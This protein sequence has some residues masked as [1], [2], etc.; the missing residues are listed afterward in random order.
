MPSGLINA[1]WVFQR[2]MT[3]VFQDLA[4]VYINDTLIT[5]DNIKEEFNDLENVLKLLQ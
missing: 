5:S 2:A 3:K 4:L 1:P